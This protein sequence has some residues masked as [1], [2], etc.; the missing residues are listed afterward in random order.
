MP[1]KDPNHAQHQDAAKH[2]SAAAKC[3]NMA[4]LHHL[5]AER[6]YAVGDLEAAGIQAYYAHARL[7]EAL[8]HSEKGAQLHLKATDATST[9]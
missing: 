7:L 4:A 2:H 9:K 5:E 3:H 1:K 8:R 6:R